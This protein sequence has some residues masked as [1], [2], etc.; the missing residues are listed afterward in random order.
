MRSP[1]EIRAEIEKVERAK[2][3]AVRKAERCDRRIMELACEHSDALNEENR[4]RRAEAVG[5][6]KE[7]SDAET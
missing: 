4:R 2:K 6:V 3:A 1:E 7:A 5:G